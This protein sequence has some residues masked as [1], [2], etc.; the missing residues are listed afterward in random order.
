MNPN[1]ILGKTTSPKRTCYAPDI[2]KLST[3]SPQI[4]RGSSKPCCVKFLTMLK[5]R[6]LFKVRIQ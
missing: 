1:A 3:R 6:E 4:N 2:L 5:L